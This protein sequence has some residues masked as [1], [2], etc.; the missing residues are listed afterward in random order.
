[1]K[2][3]TFHEIPQ[4]RLPAYI[5]CF[6]II[7]AVLYMLSVLRYL[8]YPVKRIF[9]YQKKRILS[10]FLVCLSVTALG[11]CGPGR[12]EAQYFKVSEDSQMNITVRT[13][14]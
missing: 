14:I 13:F 11:G 9:S 8:K 6:I 12:Q 7:I 4:G 10:V 3:Y 5:L 1:M 2:K